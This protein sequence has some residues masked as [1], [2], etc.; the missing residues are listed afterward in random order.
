MAYY[1]MLPAA[2]DILLLTVMLLLIMSAYIRTYPK[3]NC[4]VINNGNF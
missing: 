4:Q 2:D 1:F 3:R